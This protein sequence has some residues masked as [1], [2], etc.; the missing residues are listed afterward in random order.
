MGVLYLESWYSMGDL[1]LV[2]HNMLG[3]YPLES[4]WGWAFSQ[5]MPFPA[6]C[7]MQ[8]VIVAHQLLTSVSSQYSLLYLEKPKLEGGC[9]FEL[10]SGDLPVWSCRHLYLGVLLSMPPTSFYK[11]RSFKD[12]V[13]WIRGRGIFLDWRH[14]HLY[15][16][17]IRSIPRPSFD[18]NRLQGFLTSGWGRGILSDWSHYYSY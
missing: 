12:F 17:V 2:C 18:K 9:C 6:F 15:L 4:S 10:R 7:L 11:N 14:C 1:L 3:S 16:K 5:V 8:F 13:A